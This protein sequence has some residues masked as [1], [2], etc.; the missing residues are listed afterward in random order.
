MGFVED[1]TGSCSETGIKCDD[2]GTEEVSIKVEEVLDIKD[3]FTEDVTFL[4]I[5]TEQEVRLCVCVCVCVRWRHLM[6][7]GHFLPQKG[8]CEIML[9]Y[10]LFVL[11]FERHIALK[12]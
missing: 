3:E 8:N 10:F 6:L 1:E 11:F 7:L 9:D 4:P 12:F 2:D 5:K